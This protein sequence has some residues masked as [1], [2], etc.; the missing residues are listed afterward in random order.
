MGLIMP[1]M[2]LSG[3]IFPIESMPS[4]LQWIS[5]IIPARWFN[6]G[7]KKL[8]IQGASVHSVLKEMMILL[9]MAIFIITVSLKNIKIRL[10]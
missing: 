1:V 9:G 6:D 8:I 4:I 2:I 3:Y 10:E 5:G 7:A